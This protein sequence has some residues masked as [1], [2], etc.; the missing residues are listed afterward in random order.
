VPP[1]SVKRSLVFLHVHKT[2]GS[3]LTG[4]LSNRFAASD[5]LQLY[6]GPE[7][8]LAGLERF[9]YVSGHL[10]ASF[11]D[12]FRTPPFVVTFLRDPVERALS[13]YSYTRSFPLDYRPSVLLYG[14]GREAHERVD[15]Y[16]RLARECSIEDLI[17]RAPEVACEYLGNRQAR[18]LGGSSPEGGDE[19]LEDAL[20]G[21]E[22]CDFV[23]LTERLDESVGWLAR[24]LGWCPMD[25]LPQANI[26]SVRLR[27][28]QVSPEAIDALSELTGIDRELYVHGRR[29]YE[30]RLRE[31]GDADDPRDRSAQIPDATLTSDLRFEQAIAGGGW[32]SR[33]RA[34]DEPWFC[35]IGDSATAWVDLEA[36]GADSLVVEIPHVMD[37]SVLGTLRITVDGKT[38]PHEL[39]ESGGAVVAS[40]RLRR[41]RF[42]RRARVTR[43][44]L[45]VDRATRPCDV[46][47]DSPDNRELAIAVRRIALV[48]GDEA[49]A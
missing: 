31:W 8:D 3:A 36:R 14:Q 18:V 42:R 9:R 41:W 43:V 48:S 40:A 20:E 1:G 19:R 39:R 6:F 32:L 25:R 27:R 5:C 34:G 44:Q 21:L 15:T 11:L 26:S 22:R 2:G 7:P 45:Q 23:G 10:S 24:R 28:D 37:N 47:P 30:R 4:A 29:L 35:W 13:S 33:E 38:V 49:P 16:R 46:D 12:E 17:D